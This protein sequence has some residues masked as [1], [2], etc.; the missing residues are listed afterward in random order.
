MNLCKKEAEEYADDLYPKDYE[1][2][3]IHVEDN[4]FCVDTFSWEVLEMNIQ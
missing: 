1:Y 3:R 4:S 2:E